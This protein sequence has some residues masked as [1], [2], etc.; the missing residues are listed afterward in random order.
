VHF[1]GFHSYLDWRESNS[2][3][4]RHVQSQ[5]LLE[6]LTEMMPV[7]AGSVSSLLEQ[8]VI[9]KAHTNAKRLAS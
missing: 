9:Q 7:R 1:Y 8:R 4:R 3:A 2:G 5:P 6:E